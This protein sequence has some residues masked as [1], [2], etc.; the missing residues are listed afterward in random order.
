MQEEASHQGKVAPNLENTLIF[1][2]RNFFLDS[3][4]L[5][6]HHHH[7]AELFLTHCLK[8]RDRFITCELVELVI[9]LVR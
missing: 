1:N 9:M 8:W 3:H 2:I 4:L 6:S 7:L 5:A